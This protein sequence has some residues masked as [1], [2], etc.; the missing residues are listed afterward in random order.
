MKIRPLYLV[1]VLLSIAGLAY[2]PTLIVGAPREQSMAGHFEGQR[3]RGGQIV[4]EECP[5][6]ELRGECRE[7]GQF[8]RDGVRQ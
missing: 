1:A 8:A 5:T 3:P 2:A 6:Q 4:D 7:F